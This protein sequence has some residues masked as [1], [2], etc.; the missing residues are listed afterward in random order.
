MFTYAFKP[1][2][3]VNSKLRAVHLKFGSIGAV[4]SFASNFFTELV[5]PYGSDEHGIAYFKIGAPRINFQLQLI[6][7]KQSIESFIGDGMMSLS[8]MVCNMKSNMSNKSS[9]SCA[10]QPFKVRKA[11]LGTFHQGNPKYGTTAGIQCTSNAFIAIC[12]SVVKRVSIWKSF[13][14]DYILDQGDKLMKLLEA[15]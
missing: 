10:L 6:P 7:H 2:I 8:P 14:L 5:V 13:D 3:D 4:R 1:Y 15:R 11:M 12:F 9:E